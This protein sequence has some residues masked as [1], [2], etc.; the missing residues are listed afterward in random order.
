MASYQWTTAYKQ[1]LSDSQ[2]TLSQRLSCTNVMESLGAMENKIT[3]SV[4]DGDFQ[5]TVWDS[6][7]ELLNSIHW[8]RDSFQ[9]YGISE[10]VVNKNDNNICGTVT[11]IA[12]GSPQP[13]EPQ[14]NT[15]QPEEKPTPATNPT[16]N[17]KNNPVTDTTATPTPPTGLADEPSEVSKSKVG[18][19]TPNTSEFFLNVEVYIEGVQ[20]PHS[21]ATVSYGLATPPSC[22]VIIPASSLIRDL[23]ETTKVHIFFEDL[24]PDESGVYQ[25]R[26]LFDGELAGFQYNVDANGGTVSLSAIH[27]SAYL[28]L[29]QLMTLDAS[30]YLFNPNPRMVG[31][32]TMPM[33]FGQNKISTSLISNIM[34]GKG[35][36]SMADIVYQLTRAI[37]VGT[38]DSAVGKYYHDKLGNDKEGWKIL[39]RMYGISKG[40]VNSPVPT[41]DTQYKADGTLKNNT[42][43]NTKSGKTTATADVSRYYQKGDFQSDSDP[44]KDSEWP[45]MNQELLDKLD[46]L[47]DEIRK[48]NGG[49]TKFT[50]NS[51]F[52]SEAYNTEIGGAAQ[53]YH[54]KGMA[55]DLDVPTEYVTGEQLADLAEKVGFG[56]IH[57]YSDSS[58]V[59]VDVGDV[60]R[61]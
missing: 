10:I 59:H 19:N 35:Y 49:F 43:S 50:V 61:W 39:K 24:L 37:L 15:I 25:W 36:E 46:A 16:T 2:L 55:A 8:V 27:S 38:Q 41:Y 57:F 12:D 7:D 33:V 45:G 52:R 23:P 30:E 42:N 31:D 40:I 3:C 34:K 20:V 17:I 11:V 5:V 9:R 60:R 18:V 26:L 1:V 51:G 29:M 44:N 4:S 32:A 53:S 54:V 58:F 48:Y 21:S 22:T 6:A 47:T 56:G 28:T 14:D 13:E